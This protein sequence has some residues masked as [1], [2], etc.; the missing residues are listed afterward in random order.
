MVKA[1]RVKEAIFSIEAKLIE[2]KE[3]DSKAKPG[4]KSGVLAI[5]EGVNFW[6]REDA[7]NDEGSLIDPAVLKPVSRLGGIT[8]GRTISGYELPRPDFEAAKGAGEL[9]GLIE[10]KVEGQ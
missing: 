6:A 7:I 4:T 10:K 5:L 1:E 3:F 2:T 8:Y 9:D